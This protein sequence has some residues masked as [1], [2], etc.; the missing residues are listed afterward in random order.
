MQ[1]G[2]ETEDEEEGR[3]DG[4]AGYEEYGADPDE[5]RYGTKGEGNEGVKEAGGVEDNVKASREVVRRGA[6][7]GNSNEFVD[8]GK[9]CERRENWMVM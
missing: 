7:K 1:P 6:A 5:T 9:V 4:M 2:E 8:G 3:E